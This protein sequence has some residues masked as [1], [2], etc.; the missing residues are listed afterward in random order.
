MH[1]Y[2]V[3]KKYNPI[4]VYNAL[5]KVIESD[6][7][8]KTI[9]EKKDR[10][11]RLNYKSDFHM[12]ILPACMPNEF[13][14][15]KIAIPEKKLANW[16]FGNPKAFAN[17]FLKRA[18]EVNLSMLRTYSELL[19]EAKVEVEPLPDELYLKTPLQ[20][21]V[22]LI[23]RARDVYYEKKQNPISS[24]V[25]TT[26]MAQFYKGEQSIFISLDN[27]ISSIKISYADSIKMNKRFQI[28][29]PVDE[30]EEFT[31][32]W[33][34]KDYLSFNNFIN[35]FYYKWQKLKIS[36]EGSNKEYIELFGEGIYK[37]TL[38]EQFKTFS[39]NS[40]NTFTKSAGLILS[41]NAFTDRMGR[42]NINQ[43]VKNEQHH[44]F[45]ED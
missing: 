8:Y 37:K 43:G 25:L 19:L 38:T 14:K 18:N 44:N 42:V 29:N 6:A 23:K 7:Y 40:N 28:F 2:E 39:K 27:I 1:I 16:S 3:Y 22:Q 9:C 35:D 12:D 15:E 34:D 21:A 33:T 41:N 17:W 30:N 36:F 24:I 5:L 10:C 32:S 4:D 31:D 13:E 26:L 45:G 20:R 11:I